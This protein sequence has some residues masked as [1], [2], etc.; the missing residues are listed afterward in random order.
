MKGRIVSLNVS[1]G[2]VP[3]TPV[4]EAELT[5]TGLISD[6]QA[7]TKFHGGPK[8]ALCLFSFELIQRLREEGH[9]ISP[10]SVGENITISGLDWEALRPGAK[11]ALGDKVLIQ[12]TSYTIPCPTIAMSFLDGQ[13]KRIS[14]KLRPGNSRLYAR[15][16][17]PGRLAI[18][19]SVFVMDGK[20]WLSGV[21]EL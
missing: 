16:L 13:Y 9:P 10:G 3:K 4:A 11:L 12:V 7:N 20:E 17:H 14:Q 8:R 19:Q 21:P 18:G 1:R 2:G 5:T 15:V 6:R